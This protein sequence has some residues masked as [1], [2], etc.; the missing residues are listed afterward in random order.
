M[1][2]DGL[3]ALVSE[4]ASSVG[5]VN[6]VYLFG[7]RA[8]LAPSPN[9]YDIAVLFDERIVDDRRLMYK[10][11]DELFLLLHS[12][13][14]P[15]DIVELNVAPDT[16]L[17][18]VLRDKRVLFCADRAYRTDWEVKSHFLMWDREPMT[19]RYQDALF[20]RLGKGC[21]E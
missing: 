20:A 19:L 2:M 3:A 1:D 6:T 4:H 11:A 18:N 13:L 7:S 17:R 15:L 12:H 5:G 16:L 10:K 14:S 8:R 9:D 21:N